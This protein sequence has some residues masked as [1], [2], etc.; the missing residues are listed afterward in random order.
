MR[1]TNLIIEFGFLG[2]WQ[3]KRRIKI[4]KIFEIL[5]KFDFKV[6]DFQDMSIKDQVILVNKS[7]ILGGIHGAG[8][9]N[10]L[11]LERQK[12]CRS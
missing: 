8:L 11:F 10:M 7:D 4:W 12:G 2:I 1:R 3:G 9:T 6:I 5:E